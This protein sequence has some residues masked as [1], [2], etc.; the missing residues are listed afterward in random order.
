MLQ[1]LEDC[2]A[3][4]I[5]YILA[6]SIARFARNV[7]DCLSII[8]ELKNMNP[9]VGV[10]FEA[11]N[12]YTLDST[13]ALVLTI[14]ATLAE[15]ESRNKSVIMNWSIDRRF[16][17]GIFLTPELLGYDRD[18]N[19]EL[20]INPQEAETVKVI[21][22]LYINGWT[23]KEIADLLTEYGRKTKLG[24]EV[25]NPGTIRGVI[26]NERHCG[27]ILARKT[28][29]PNFKNH[30]AKKNEGKRTQY[31]QRDHHDPI[32]SREV[33]NAAN[34]LAASRT[35]GSKRKPLP[36]LSVIDGGMLAGYVPVDKD[37]KGFSTE[38]YRAACESVD[39]KEE[40]V[41]PTGK[42]LNMAGFQI[43]RSDFFPSTEDLKMTI[44]QGNLRFSTSC[45]R[46]FEDV[47]Y[48]ELLLNTVKN[49]IAIRPCSADCPNAIHWGR[50]REEKW[51]V[52]SVGSRGLSSTLFDMMN[53][54]EEAKYRFKG[55]FISR[56][57]DKLL[58][59]QLDEP[60]VTRTETQ[61]VVPDEP[62][63][64][65][66]HEEIVMKETIRSYPASW[67]VSFGAPITFLT[68]VNR[69]EQA[70]YAGEWD[71]LRPAKEV[72]GMNILAADQ[73]AELMR[74]A[75]TIIEGWKAS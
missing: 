48:V 55:Q 2:R 25:W 24:N 60:V 39:Q 59:F 10:Y 65:D 16:S 14:M 71:V 12:L 74:E 9:P 23:P 47:E 63:T 11:D 37:W 54:E 33:Y 53:W 21:Y 66:E 41:L 69:L 75:E 28:Y 31:R 19:G 15:E 42:R 45:L 61:V 43:V 34:H 5:D 68:R 52:S 13:G 64:D 58:L 20:V 18:E 62:E 32:V 3:G 30:K 8:E 17:R 44:S 51:I 50:L 36:V 56:G 72:E 7:V 70:H 6:K 4:K 27:D 22:D 73:L 46:K 40:T 38:D 1:M 29:T 67:L 57:D 26:E 49:C 35:Y